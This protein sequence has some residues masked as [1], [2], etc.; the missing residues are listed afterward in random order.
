MENR[1][2][3]QSF[4]LVI[5]ICLLLISC[6]GSQHSNNN[7]AS[8]DNVFVR[9]DTSLQLPLLELAQQYQYESSHIITLKFV[10]SMQV[11]SITARDSVDILLFTNNNLADSARALGLIDTIPPVTIG[12]TLPCLIVPRL[13]PFVMSNLSDLCRFNLKIAFPNPSM[14]V[15]GAFALELLKNDKIYDQV[16]PKLNIVGNSAREVAE[17]IAQS[18]F[19][20]GIGWN[21]SNNWNPDLFDIVLL[22]PSEVP[23]IALI[24]AA[25]TTK[26]IHPTSTDR[27]I[28]YLKSDRCQ[29]VFRKWG[30][31][32][33]PSDLDAY[34]PDATIG[35][36]PVY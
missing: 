22:L 34:A 3:F 29:A 23:R 14:D 6:G 13:N 7:L 19:D 27:F 31:L 35:G 25:K 36:K 15:L 30:F 11:I 24:C 28:T 21:F 26:P 20:V 8:S 1:H 9:A 12:Y 10:P 18:E 2:Q 17:R 32:V 4:S 16:Q 5:L 33:S